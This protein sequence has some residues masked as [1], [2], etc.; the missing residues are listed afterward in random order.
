METAAFFLL[1]VRFLV[2]PS[3]AQ[4]PRL[5]PRSDF[6]SRKDS[7]NSHRKL[8]YTFARLAYSSNGWR[9]MW[10]TDYPAADENF[11]MGLRNWCQSSLA[12]SDDPV[13]CPPSAKELFE[14][15]FMYAVEPG[16]MELSTE[17]AA[18]LR[19]YLLRGGFL[20]L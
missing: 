9:R 1:L 13:S 20:M 17:D 2:P 4:S 3:S 5:T 7:R 14:Y 12:I 11:I 16:Y 10:T 18:N 6:R 8:E 15:P 19:E